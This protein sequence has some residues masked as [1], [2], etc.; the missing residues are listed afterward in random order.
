M[1]CA[2]AVPIRTR[3]TCGLHDNRARQQGVFPTASI[4][5]QLR[6]LPRRA[7]PPPRDV[8]EAL[9]LLPVHHFHPRPVLSES[10]SSA[11]AGCS[12]AETCPSPTAL[13]WQ[14]STATE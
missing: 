5:A 10:P 6:F 12:R 8:R 7:D 4:H 13:Q 1:I 14:S 2:T 11:D 3:G 9:L